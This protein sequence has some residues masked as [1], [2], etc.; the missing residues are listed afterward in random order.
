[1][2]LFFDSYPCI[3]KSSGGRQD[4]CDGVLAVFS[5]SLQ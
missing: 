5:C 2:V 4:F 1:M 3:L